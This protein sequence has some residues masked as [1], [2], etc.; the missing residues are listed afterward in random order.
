MIHILP[1]PTNYSIDSDDAGTI[2][3]WLEHTGCTPQFVTIRNTTDGLIL[4][5]ESDTDPAPFLATFPETEIQNESQ[6]IQQ[7]LLTQME[8]MQQKLDALM[9]AL[10]V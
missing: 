3:D 2:H 8:S 4:E 10:G 9:N 1:L 6:D 7:A 5:I